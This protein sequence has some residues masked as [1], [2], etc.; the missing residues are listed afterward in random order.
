[1]KKKPVH[2]DE[3]DPVIYPRLLWV[4]IPSE[5]LGEYF[6]FLDTSSNKEISYDKVLDDIDANGGIMM[7]SSV[8]RKSDGKLGVMVLVIADDLINNTVIPHEAI[9][10]ADYFCDQLGI[11]T[12]SF[13]NGNEPYAYLVGWAGGSISNT[14]S[15]MIAEKHEEQ[16]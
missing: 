1:M 3:Y 8:V 2:V 13:E 15:K 11:Y 7:T 4:T 6:T 16:L 10:V 12:Q 9:H 14:V 5:Y